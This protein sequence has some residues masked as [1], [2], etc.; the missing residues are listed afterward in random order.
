MI[1]Y[2]YRMKASGV[3]API[4]FEEEFYATAWF[5]RMAQRFPRYTELLEPIVIETTTQIKVL[6]HE[7]N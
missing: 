7:Q 3:V 6:K 2:A 1:S 5:N 4:R